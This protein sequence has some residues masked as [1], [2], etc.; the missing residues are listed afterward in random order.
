MNGS[1]LY[2]LIRLFRSLNPDSVK[3]LSKSKND[4]GLI[5]FAGFPDEKEQVDV[6]FQKLH[7]ETYGI[8]AKNMHLFVPDK[9]RELVAKLGKEPNYYEPAQYSAICPTL[10]YKHIINIVSRH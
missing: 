7:F 3:D 5:V 10:K 9:V 2:L 6:G 1:I 8:P 4:I